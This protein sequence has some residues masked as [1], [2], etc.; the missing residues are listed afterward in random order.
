M[1]TTTR[2]SRAR[3]LGRAVVNLPWA[4]PPA[5]GNIIG[6]SSSI[7]AWRHGR[8]DRANG[9]ARAAATGHH[10]RHREQ[11]G[12][13]GSIGR[14]AGREVSAGWQQ[15]VLFVFD[16]HAVNPFLQNL[17]FD[18][19][20]DLEPVLCK[21]TAPNVVATHP[22]HPFKTFADATCGEG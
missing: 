7:P 4:R 11:A 20:K 5:T 10:H 19:E 17:S 2:R 13:S 18:T 6:S 12:A 21:S 14:R 8:S 1:T 3:R 22:G 16:T 15:L 9:A